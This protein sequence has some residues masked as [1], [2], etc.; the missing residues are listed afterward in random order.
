MTRVT[1]GI[2][3]ALLA[4]VG[5][6]AQG[7][8]DSWDNLKQ[9]VA[10][11]KIEVVEMNLKKLTGT[12]V[13]FSEQEISVQSAD[14]RMSVP[15][16]EVFRVGV[17]RSRSRNIGI[18]AAIGLGAGVAIGVAGLKS[19]EEAAQY[20]LLAIPFALGVGAGVGAAMPPGYRTIYRAPKR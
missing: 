12:F 5:A 15:R 11:Q 17:V 10:G 19:G 18:G 7:P 6:W 14:G 3:L 13:G 20:S 1:L 8:A 16:A 4:C 9:L 2:L